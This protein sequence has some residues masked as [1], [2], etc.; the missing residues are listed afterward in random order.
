VRL[1]LLFWRPPRV[2][3]LLVSSYCCSLLIAKAADAGIEV[4]PR[5]PAARV[6][7][8]ACS[9]LRMVPPFSSGIVLLPCA[10]WRAYRA[11]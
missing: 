8:V 9:S 2:L 1:L 11:R 7:P 6:L 4:L 3:L 5:L 10:V